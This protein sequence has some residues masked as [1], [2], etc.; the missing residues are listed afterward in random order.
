GEFI[1]DVSSVTFLHSTLR[2][3]FHR[4]EAMPKG[5][6]FY[7]TSTTER[8][9]AL[10]FYGYVLEGIACY[11]FETPP[12]LVSGATA[13]FRLYDRHGT[14]D[15]LYTTSATER[16]SVVAG[17]YISEGTACFAFSSAHPPPPG[18]VAL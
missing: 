11:V 2:L 3:V 18:R 9:N 7:T 6:H 4:E 5:D 10:A 17:G 1:E 15:H 14:G 13:L 8:D 12:A 16:D